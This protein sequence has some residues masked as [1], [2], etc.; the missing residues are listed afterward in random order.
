MS[1]TP[2]NARKPFGRARTRSAVIA[3]G[4]GASLV[5]GAGSA[6][7]AHSSEQGDVFASQTA[8][9]LADSARA[10]ADQQTKAA[11]A[12]KKAAERAG[13][14]KASRSAERPA[15]SKKANSWTKPVSGK[16]ELSA[17]YGNSGGRW[18]QKHSGQDFAVPTGTP[19]KAVHSG[20]VVKAGPNGAGDGASYGN[21]IVIK[22]DDNTYSQYAHLSKVNVKPGQKVQTGQKIGLSGSTGNSSGPHLHFEIRNTAEYGSGMDP[23]DAMRSHGVKV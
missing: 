7:A 1:K 8:S 20:T 6:V 11:E 18:A 4:L 13:D 14:G 21:A 9:L 3:A 2:K 23:V 15:A 19:V 12:Q 5:L 16:Y 17:G 22:H 10:Q